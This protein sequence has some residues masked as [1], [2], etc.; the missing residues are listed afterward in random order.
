MLRDPRRRAPR[1]V[2]RI[3]RMLASSESTDM[4]RRRPCTTEDLP[5]II[6]IVS[7][8]LMSFSEEEP[9]AFEP[10]YSDTEVER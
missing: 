5:T 3:G 8:D 6:D 1:G 10:R 9:T 7:A 2:K 4:R